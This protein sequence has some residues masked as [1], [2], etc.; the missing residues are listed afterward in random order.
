MIIL[1]PPPQDSISISMFIQ[2]S[3]HATSWTA[4]AALMSRTRVCVPTVAASSPSATLA[5]VVVAKAGGEVSH[6]SKSGLILS[7]IKPAKLV[8]W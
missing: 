8:C 6:T 5:V 4:A 7:R 3:R 2:V 1:Y